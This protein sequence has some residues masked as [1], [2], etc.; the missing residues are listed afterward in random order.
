MRGEYSMYPAMLLLM[1]GSPPLAR[2]VQIKAFCLGKIV[3]IT[4]A[5]AGSTY[6][7]INYSVILEDHPRLRGEYQM[8]DANY[9]F[10]RGSPPLARG[11][12]ICRVAYIICNRITPACAGSTYEFFNNDIEKWDHPRLRGEYLYCCQPSF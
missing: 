6:Y 10:L 8:A 1:Q 4:P 5:C 9:P 2:G 7:F 3:R 11:V 12:L